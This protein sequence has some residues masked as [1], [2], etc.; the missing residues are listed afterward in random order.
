MD[1]KEN[2]GNGE[3]EKMEVA[4][5]S[6]AVTA[7]ES[8]T[9]VEEAKVTKSPKHN[10]KRKSTDGH[11]FQKKKKK[12]SHSI[13]KNALMQLNELK[14]GLKYVVESQSGPPHNP[15][16]EVSV[17]VNDQKYIGRG[18]SKQMAK[19]AAAQAALSSFVQFRN[20]P[21]AMNIINQ[22]R[23]TPDFTMDNVENEACNFNKFEVR[24][25]G[26]EEEVLISSGHPV[27]KN[28]PLKVL[29]EADKKNPVMLL[30]E[31]HPGLVYQLKEENSSAPS[32]RFRM[33][34]EVNGKI[35]EGTG[36]N[37]KLAKAAAAR[38]VLS[39][40]YNVS[41]SLYP[42]AL[43]PNSSNEAELFSFSQETADK[44]GKSLMSCFNEVMIIS[45]EYSK[46][47][48]IAG[49]A[50]T[51]DPEMKDV[52]IISFGTGTKCINGEHISM[53]GANIND[54][55]AEIISRRCLKDFLYTNLELLLEGEEEESVFMKREKGGYC[56]KPHVKFHLYIST[57]PCGDARIFSPHEAGVVEAVDRH[58][59]RNSRGVLRTKIESG[60]G[61]IPVKGGQCIQ[62][63]DSILPGQERLLTM[64][65][66]DKIASWNVLG[67][68]GALL[69]HFIEPVYLES[70]ILGGLFHPNHLRRALF[71]R[72]ENELK[73]LPPSFRIQK[74]KMCA[75]TSSEMR[76]LAKS[77]NYSVN[78]TVGLGRAEVVNSVNGKTESGQV[79]RLAKK[80]FFQRFMNIYDRLTHTD[81]YV[82][83]Q[84]PV[85]AAFKNAVKPYK[86]AQKALHAAFAS[87]GLGYWVKKPVEQNDFS[88]A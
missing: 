42:N 2:V 20:T 31:I 44:I 47:K 88:H 46:W 78:W 71:A 11:A 74:P 32:Q 62:T 10:R 27:I 33:A 64:S 70:V 38:A 16:F 4:D 81:S 79:S 36:Q 53:V 15:E 23:S 3:P 39:T 22:P 75:T 61:T 29:T 18:N 49:I 69:T 13:Q 66:S 72:I 21:E 87:A 19:H 76:H 67:L 7:S 48:V 14:P 50:M 56:L 40:L 28:F 63:W 45:P 60:E 58:P 80:S 24:K 54:C 12:L 34:V 6:A 82:A 5:D 55:H 65:C 43:L 26:G 73:D 83:P 84:P 25:N 52:Q 51:K 86:E 85:Y 17:T 59:N 37:K 1:E 35:Y 57:A 9:V 41:Y 8:S 68:Q 77:P 30:N